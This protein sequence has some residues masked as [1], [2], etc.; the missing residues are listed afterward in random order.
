MST[1]LA[2]RADEAFVEGV[3][4]DA[5]YWHVGGGGQLLAQVAD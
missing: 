5:F 2:L 4:D 3:E 1:S